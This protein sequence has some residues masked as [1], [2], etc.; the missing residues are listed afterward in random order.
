MHA[1]Y[2]IQP[3]KPT[4]VRSNGSLFWYA[5]WT[6]IW[7]TV[8]VIDPIYNI[9][10]T[11]DDTIETLNAMIPITGYGTTLDIVLFCLALPKVI[12][13][14]QGLIIRNALHRQWIPWTHIRG[15]ANG[16]SIEITYED[17]QG[18]ERVTDIAVFSRHKSSLITFDGK[19]TR[20]HGELTAYWN[21]C[22]SLRLPDEY[23]VP[24]WRH[25][26]AIPAGT[27]ASLA[28]WSIGMETLALL[29]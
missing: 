21:D 7:T 28:I 11:S 19:R 8:F 26:D 29:T 5:A 9:A 16:R 10:T 27:V 22:K 24:P 23:T 6:A 20:L 13:S 14:D 2:P 1:A 3:I 4:T 15:I 18:E 17:A 25:W 12:V